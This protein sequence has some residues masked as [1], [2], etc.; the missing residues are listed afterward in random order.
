MQCVTDYLAWASLLKTP[1]KKDR[2]RHCDLKQKINVVRIS[3]CCI[4]LCEFKHH[5]G[6]K[7]QTGEKKRF[8]RDCQNVTGGNGSSEVERSQFEAEQE[9]EAIIT[10][11]VSLQ[12][13]QCD[14]S[15]SPSSVCTDEDMHTACVT[16]GLFGE[17]SVLVCVSL[18]SSLR[19]PALPVSDIMTSSHLWGHTRG[20]RDYW[21]SVCMFLS[22]SLFPVGVCLICSRAE[23]AAAWPAAESDRCSNHRPP[24]HLTGK[25][26]QSKSEQWVGRHLN[27][28]PVCSFLCEADSRAPCQA[29]LCLLWHRRETGSQSVWRSQFGNDRHSHEPAEQMLLRRGHRPAAVRDET[30]EEGRTHPAEPMFHICGT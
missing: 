3:N 1:E 2:V 11:S 14:V 7:V 20:C 15:G 4:G 17:H 24:D 30:A 28:T 9:V 22:G 29:V 26:T 13:A 8:K 6:K 25:S 5:R 16:S 19:A 23:A 27:T 18:P 12:V 10:V 21:A